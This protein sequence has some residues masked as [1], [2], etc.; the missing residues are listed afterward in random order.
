M[1]A[2]KK[3][4]TVGNGMSVKQAAELLG[5]SPKTV[6]E[7]IAAEMIPARRLGLK[8]GKIVL[9]PVDVQAY[10]DGCKVGPKP[11]EPQMVLRHVRL[12]SP[13]RRPS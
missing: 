7:L 4:W 6:Y 9:D 11:S 10:W 8:G 2:A 13:S 12:P 1:E 3:K 5:I